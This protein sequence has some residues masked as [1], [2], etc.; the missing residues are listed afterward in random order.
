MKK[1]LI[2]AALILFSSCAP[3]GTNC[4]CPT[5]QFKCEE[6]PILIPHPS[7]GYT[8]GVTKD[9]LCRVPLVCPA[10]DDEDYHTHGRWNGRF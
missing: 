1:L 2:V 9:C 3:F 6:R 5:G 10:T 8:R 4:Y 7:F